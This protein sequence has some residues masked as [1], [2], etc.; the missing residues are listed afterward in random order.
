MKK[1]SYCK[2]CNGLTPN[3]R[4]V[5]TK[6][7]IDGWL[8]LL[9]DLLCKECGEVTWKQLEVTKPLSSGRTI[10]LVTVTNKSTVDLIGIFEK[11][12]N[13]L[14][15]HYLTWSRRDQQ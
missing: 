10:L 15:D 13:H 7:T 4:K 6:R 1:R 5:N 2:R 8:V 9:F 12:K 3:R 11:T 14:D